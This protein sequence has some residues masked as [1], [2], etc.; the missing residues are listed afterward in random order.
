VLCFTL[1]KQFKWVSKAAMFRVPLIGWNMRLCN[2]IPL[3]RGKSASIQQMWRRAREWLGRGVSIMMFP[4][5]TRSPDGRLGS[6]KHG[7]FTLAREAGVPVVPIV[8]HGG[9][10]VMPKHRSSMAASAS[11]VIEVLEPVSPAPFA[12]T[13]SYMDAVRQRIAERLA[14]GPLPAGEPALGAVGERP[15]GD[16]PRPDDTEPAG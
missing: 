12:D 1:F 6:F 3:E 2:Y 5:G 16:R 4:E 7:A 15:A 8:I 14:R 13:P 9:H 11:L 10:A